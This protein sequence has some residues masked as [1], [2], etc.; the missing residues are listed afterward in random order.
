MEKLQKISDRFSKLTE[1]EQESIE[2]EIEKLLT[3]LE[4]GVKDK[5]LEYHRT[6]SPSCPDCQS[7][8]FRRNGHQQGS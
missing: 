8:N 3:T 5:H 7:K 1:Q 2:S 6:S 4:T